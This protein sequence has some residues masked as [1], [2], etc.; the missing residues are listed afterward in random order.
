M[1]L[2]FLMF[3]LSCL[4]DCDLYVYVCVC[5]CVPGKRA[6]APV[7]LVR[8]PGGTGA[9]IPASSGFRLSIATFACSDSKWRAIEQIGV[10]CR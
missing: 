3:P 4:V 10:I 8:K 6:A 5:P 2:P 7:I 9:Q 1:R